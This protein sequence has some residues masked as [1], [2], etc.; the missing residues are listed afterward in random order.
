MRSLLGYH[1]ACNGKD[2]L[3]LKIGCVL[4][5]EECSSLPKVVNNKHSI[6]KVH[7]S[8]LPFKMSIFSD[9]SSVFVWSAFGFISSNQTAHKPSYYAQVSVHRRDHLPP[10]LC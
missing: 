9:M 1:A 6:V 7:L 8:F 10:M 4:A 2:F 3:P 5:P